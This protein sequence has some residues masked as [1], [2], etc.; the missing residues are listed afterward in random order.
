MSDATALLTDPADGLGGPRGAGVMTK[1]GIGNITDV[2]NYYVECNLQ[3][4]MHESLF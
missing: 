4:L 3:I 2:Y 1:K